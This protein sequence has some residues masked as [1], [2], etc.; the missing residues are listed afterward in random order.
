VPTPLAAQMHNLM[1]LA[2][3]MGLGPSDTSSMMR[4]YETALKREVRATRIE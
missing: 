4:V 2:R 1:R 3:G